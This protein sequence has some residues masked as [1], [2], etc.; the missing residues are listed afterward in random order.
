M[1]T[2]ETFTSFIGI[3]GDLFKD[4]TESGMRLDVC[5]RKG[6]KK[7]RSSLPISPERKQKI[8]QERA[9]RA[10]TNQNQEKPA[11]PLNLP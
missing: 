7:I 9:L 4:K 6:F 3:D 2:N 1:P 10:V 8:R 11:A 5:D